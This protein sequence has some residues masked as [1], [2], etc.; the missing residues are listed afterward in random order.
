MLSKTKQTAH[1]A[2]RLRERAPGPPVSLG[3]V[4]SADDPREE[5]LPLPAASQARGR[6][7][8]SRSSGN[9]TGSQGIIAGHT[10]LDE[11]GGPEKASRTLPCPIPNFI[12]SGEEHPKP[13]F[14]S[15]DHGPR[16]SG[17]P[18]ATPTVA[19]GDWVEGHSLRA[20]ED[21]S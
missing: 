14:Y 2:P 17:A 4:V 21:T 11:K 3:T 12:P 18:L 1:I 13:S 8:Q 16:W 15:G 20:T 19:W 5:M 6:P 9:Q 10:T 7:E